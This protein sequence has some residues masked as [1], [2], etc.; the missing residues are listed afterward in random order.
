MFS[1]VRS[2]GVF[3]CKSCCRKY[4]VVGLDPVS[5]MRT[6]PASIVL[7]SYHRNGIPPPRLPSVDIKSK[8]EIGRL[9]EAGH[10]TGGILDKVMDLVQVGIT[11]D[12]LDRY[13]HDLIVQHAAYP[14][15]LNYRGYPKSICTSVNNVLCHGIPNSR[16][17]QDGD[18]ISID[19]S[20]FYKGVFGDCCSTRVVGEG[21]ST[22]HKLAKVTRD[23]TLA[24]IETCKPGTRLSSVGNTISKY[25]KE[26]G[27]SICKEFIGHGIGSYFHGLP[28]VYHYANSHGPT[29]RPGMVFTIE[30]ILME[31]RDTMAILAD[32][33]T[34]VSADSKRAAQF[35]HTILITD[36][37]PEILSPHR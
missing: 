13:A 9:R 16:E 20:I 18:I 1:G 3:L 15:P 5:E 17:L 27:L 8:D 19:V 26:A 25:A 28:E 6:V 4:S 33:W 11:T 37:E 36:S 22:A 14:A 30:P 32:G 21:D 23:S 35:E 2:R 24:A 7:P 31:G 12:E 10:I 34:A 29:L